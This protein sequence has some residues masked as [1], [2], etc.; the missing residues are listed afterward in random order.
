LN[1]AHFL[2]LVEVGKI[3]IGQAVERVKYDELYVAKTLFFSLKMD[4]QI[5]FFFFLNSES[6]LVL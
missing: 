5:V 1:T 3:N 2:K 4:P 6:G